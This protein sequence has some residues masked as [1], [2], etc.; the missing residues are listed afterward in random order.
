MPV[1]NCAHTKK[2]SR[3]QVRPGARK[4]HDGGDEVD[5]AEQRRE[6]DEQ[7][8]DEPQRL[9]VAGRQ[10]GERRVR[11]PAVVRRAAGH[12]EADQHHDPPAA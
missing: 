8:A 9:A 5:G 4:L 3:N 12:E 6:D 11:R 2:G 10:I 1:M 7:H